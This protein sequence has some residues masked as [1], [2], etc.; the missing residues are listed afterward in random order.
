MD[1]NIED[2]NKYVT[3]HRYGGHTSYKCN[4]GYWFVSLQGHASARDE[5]YR[6]FSAHWQDGEYQPEAK[7]QTI[8]GWIMSLLRKFS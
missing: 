7:T 6:N 5:A 2:F 4:K 3:A 1:F 8:K